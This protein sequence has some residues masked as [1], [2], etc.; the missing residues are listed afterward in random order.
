MENRIWFSEKYNVETCKKFTTNTIDEYLQIEYVE[1][2]EN[3]LTARLLVRN[4]LK[5]PFGNLQGGITATLV[6]SVASAAANLCVNPNHHQ[7]FG[8]ELNINHI[9]SVSNGY[10]YATA[11]PAHI[12][13][14]TQVW[15]VNVVNEAKQLS[16]TGRLTIM[17]KSINT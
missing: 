16:A 17:V 7:C 9:K 5:Q 3:T 10:I 14:S 8:L 12:G 15:W 1:M 13:R 4:E 6:E 2:T 11:Q